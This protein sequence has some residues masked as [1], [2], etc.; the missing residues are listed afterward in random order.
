MIPVN[1]VQKKSGGGFFSKLGKSVGGVAGLVGGGIGA[2]FGGPAGF[3]AGSQIGGVVGN[4]AETAGALTDKSAIKQSS[5]LQAASTGLDHEALKIIDAKTA[6]NS[7]ALPEPDR[8][9]L[10]K[11]LTTALN[12]LNERRK[13]V[14]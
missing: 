13:A 6:L 10:D 8:L 4:A 2:A 3:Q 7:S 1:P 14:V 11:H 9:S 12:T 5:A